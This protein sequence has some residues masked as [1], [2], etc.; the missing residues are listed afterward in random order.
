MAMKKMYVAV[1]LNA[2]DLES[3]ENHTAKSPYMRT[4][5]V[6]F[7]TDDKKAKAR[8]KKLLGSVPKFV[9]QIGRVNVDVSG[10]KRHPEMTGAPHVE[11]EEFHVMDRNDTDE[12]CLEAVAQPHET[13]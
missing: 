8:A 2:A 4:A 3:Y 6:F 12:G 1:G 7:S 9:Y 11:G 13:D 10:S 5:L